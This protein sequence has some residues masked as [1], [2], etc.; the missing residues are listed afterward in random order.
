[1]PG[2]RNQ[3]IKQEIEQIRKALLEYCGLDTFAMVK[4]LEALKNLLR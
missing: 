1:M 2:C 3:A 4:L